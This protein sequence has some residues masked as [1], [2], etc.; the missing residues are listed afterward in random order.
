MNEFI[1]VSCTQTQKCH[2]VYGI[3][4]TIWSISY[5]NSHL[6]FMWYTWYHKWHTDHYICCGGNVS[7]WFQN[8]KSWAV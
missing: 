6:T 8:S 3:G 7:S 1:L 4:S 2:G 5:H